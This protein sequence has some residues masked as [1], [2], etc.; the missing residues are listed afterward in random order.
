MMME[1]LIAS[2]FLLVGLEIRST[3]NKLSDLILPAFAALGGMIL[4]A[5]IFHFINPNSHAWGSVMPT[6]ITLALLVIAILG[7]RIN[8]K[9]RQFLLTLAVADDLFSLII[10]ALFYSDNLHIA[11]S[12][13][14]FLAAGIGFVLP[15]RST[16]IKVLTPWA[17]FVV[18]PAIV[19]TNLPLHIGWDNFSSSTTIGFILARLVGKTIGITLFCWILMQ[20]KVKSP[21]SLSE[22]AGVGVI[23]GMGL[24]VS[25]VIAKVSTDNSTEL[26]NI[27][28]ALFIA[29][30]IA[31]LFGF[32]WLN[33]KSTFIHGLLR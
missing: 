4:P 26:L 24:T 29:S 16:L 2:F 28:L 3:L 22:I 14:T 13:S 11:S 9:V 10:L 1:L 20:L 18:T 32:V 17:F 31:G 19:L 5:L 25:M 21:L 12:L 33:R 8:Q 15:F 30:T 27:R 23:A 7:K 6:D